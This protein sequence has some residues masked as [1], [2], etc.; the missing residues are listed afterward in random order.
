MVKLLL[1]AQPRFASPSSL[2]AMIWRRS[3]ALLSSSALVARGCWE[4]ITT[5]KLAAVLL[6]ASTA[7]H[8]Q[9]V[10]A[11]IRSSG[12]PISGNLHYR[13]RYSQMA[14]FSS[15]L[16]NY[17]T[18]SPS[19]S[20]D[21]TNASPRNPF[22]MN[23]SGG[24]TGALTGTAYSTG[25][26]EHM[27]L[28]Q[29]FV[30]KKWNLIATDDVSYRPQA[31]ISGFSGIPGIGEP[32]AGAGSNP[33][34]SQLILTVNSR[35]VDNIAT[36]GFQYNLN[37]GKSISAGGS[38]E[39][40]RYPDGTGLDTNTQTAN[41]GITW[42]LDARDSVSG[43]YRFSRFS[44]S[45]YAFNFTTNA[46]L[47]GFKRKWNRRLASEISA[48]PEWTGDS[49]SSTMPSSIGV[50]VNA[51]V[52][53]DIRSVS[54]NLD[55]SRQTN[56]GSG[57]LF[58][59]QSDMVSAALS[60]QFGRNLNIGINASYGRTA[61]LENN[62]VTNAKYGG[63][64]ANR[65]IGRYLSAFLNYTAMDQSSSSKLP[66]NT[67]GQLMHVLGFGI[68]YSPKQTHITR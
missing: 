14:E 51:T 26:F 54:T 21:Y 66:A 10:L 11:A 27:L 23:F 68:E 42:R 24:Y 36:A 20:L 50:T 17:Q 3:R 61:G 9:V 35:V 28:S 49:A 43:N 5:C 31:P 64:Q 32:I 22:S 56:G 38:S 52:T 12:I 34:S 41:A 13:F 65:Q 15:G 33:P 4:M 45:G 62:G 2:G 18:G 57:Y 67:L 25:P 16:G 44:Y 55:Y 37:Y 59:S 47:L 1:P 63:V 40:L 48:G 39:I 19:L 30:F 8:T 7:A 53:Y 6:F 58:G 60:R 29:G 46:G